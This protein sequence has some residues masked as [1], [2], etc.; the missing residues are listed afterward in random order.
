MAH[1]RAGLVFDRTRGESLTGT[2]RL[3]RS[4]RI[5]STIWCF[6]TPQMFGAGRTEQQPGRLRSPKTTMAPFRLNNRW[7]EIGKTRLDG[8]SFRH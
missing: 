6:P 8:F 3:K 7:V 4:T 2:M 5:C 1:G